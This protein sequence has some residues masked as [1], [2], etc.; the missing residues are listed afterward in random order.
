MWIF[1]AFL[2]VPL[3][4]IGLF[5]KV[6]G[7]IGLWPTLGIVLLTAI[8][9]TSLVRREGA[10]AMNDLRDSLNEL[11]DPSRPLAHGAMILVAGV[12]LLTPGFFTDAVGI[13]LLI[14]GIRDWV[15][16]HAASRVKVTRFEMGGAYRTNAYDN[17]RPNDPEIL[18]AEEAEEMTHR[19][20]PSD[21]PSGWTRH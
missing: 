2:A 8:I 6:G 4:E 11:R 14:P 20:P 13:L 1:L 19:Q 7:L 3:I 5:I 15:M 10:R 9:G 18:D 21:G 17:R 12:L 16:K